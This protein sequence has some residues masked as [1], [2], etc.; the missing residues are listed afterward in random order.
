M[1]KIHGV[2]ITAGDQGSRTTVSYVVFTDTGP[3]IGDA[4]KNQVARN[5]ENAN[6]LAKR[7]ISRKF[8]DP[9]VRAEVISTMLLVKIKE[10][11]EA[12]VGEKENDVVVTVP[13]RM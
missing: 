1:W 3:W 13:W 9:I 2:E 4:A 5:P 12:Y 10:T 8:V 7:L 11:T 6:C